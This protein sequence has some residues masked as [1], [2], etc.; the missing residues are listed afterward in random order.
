LTSSSGIGYNETIP[1]S[2]L[3]TTSIA[4]TVGYVLYTDQQ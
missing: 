4:F 2:L 1:H 3:E